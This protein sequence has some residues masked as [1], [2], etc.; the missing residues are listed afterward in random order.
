MRIC[1]ENA[2]PSPGEEERELFLIASEMDDISSRNRFLD[3]IFT[4]DTG[5]HSRV[6][7]LLKIEAREGFLERAKAGC[8]KNEAQQH[9]TGRGEAFYTKGK[10]RGSEKS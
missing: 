8:E 10:N 3:K 1:M 5:L 9:Q 6:S 2:S 7:E 4:M